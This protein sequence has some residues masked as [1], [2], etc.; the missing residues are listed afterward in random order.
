VDDRGIG[1]SGGGSISDT[2]EV[3]AGDVLAGI[4]YLKTRKEINPKQIGLIGHSEGGVIAAMIAARSKDAAFI[5]MLSGTGQS[6]EELL[7]TQLALL[8]KASGVKWKQS[9][10]QLIFKRAFMPL[11]N[12]NPTTNWRHR[13][14]TR[15]FYRVKAK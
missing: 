2:T 9:L 13:K 8:Q 6:G 7:L 14:S 4:E 15:C 11:S 5:V 1:G 12:L 10:R 3:F